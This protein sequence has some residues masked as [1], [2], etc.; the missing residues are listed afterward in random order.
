M[1]MYHLHIDPWGVVE[2]YETMPSREEVE[3]DFDNYVANSVSWSLY[4]EDED[5]EGCPTYEEVYPE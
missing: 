4:E 5:E 3:E 2:T 1:A